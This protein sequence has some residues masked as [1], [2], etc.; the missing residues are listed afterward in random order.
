MNLPRPLLAATAALAASLAIA[1]TSAADTPRTSPPLAV[2]LTLLAPTGRYDVGTVSLHLV[3]RMRQDPYWSTPHPR[4][5]MVSLWYP[6]EGK[7]RSAW[8]R[9]QP[10]HWPRAPWMTPAALAEFRPALEH[11]LE[12]TPSP[13]GNPP[14]GGPPP[15]GP[16]PGGPPPGGGVP[17]PGPTPTS[18]LDISLE[19][20]AFP[21]TD[22]RRGVP[23]AH[24]GFQFP[25]VLYS[26]AFTNGRELGTMLV[27]DLAS[28]GYIVVA[29][30][31]TYDSRVV[32]FPGGRVE[33][34]RGLEDLPNVT[35]PINREGHLVQGI[36][37]A[38]A[39]FV[40]DKLAELAADLNPDAENHPL[41]AGLHRALD[42][43]RVGMF[44]HSMGGGATAHVLAQD[45]RVVAGIDL[46]GS[47][48]PLSGLSATPGEDTAKLA[49]IARLVGARPFMAMTSS[50]SP[51][52]AGALLNGFY[53]NLSGYRRLASVV[54][55][56]HQD[57]EDSRSLYRQ[58]V[59]ASVIP[60]RLLIGTL[61]PARSVAIERAYIASFFD[62]WLKHLDNHF[63]DGNSARYPEVALY[64]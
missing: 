26:P 1:P 16:P 46:D 38:D 25:V 42:M 58:L 43:T 23:V 12:N 6:A 28:R 30:S 56:V 53:S 11:D 34:G 33:L 36:R 19:N 45:D 60:S 62:L 44:G 24:C 21:F 35:D 63:L 37:V 51:Q 57:F 29:I 15:G 14:P 17:I 54:G 18:D 55:A 22:A 5:L 10:N 49:A 48:L 3:D 7:T 61:A 13:I 9:Q 31:H 39:R 4:E 47:I 52:E 20:V 64:F 2:Q 50:K 32:E 40:I 27:E 59:D 41:P 8:S